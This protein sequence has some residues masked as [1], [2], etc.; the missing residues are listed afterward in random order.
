MPGETDQEGERNRDKTDTSI[1]KEIETKT[2]RD[3]NNDT[4]RDRKRQRQ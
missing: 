3:G 4:H 1:D 2:W